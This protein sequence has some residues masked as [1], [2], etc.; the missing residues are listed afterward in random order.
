MVIIERA[1]ATPWRKLFQD[2]RATREIEL[3]ARYPAKDVSSWLGNS[4][5][6]AMKYQAMEESFQSAADPK[7]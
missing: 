4:T 3:M 2:L 6:V 1:G 7:G 5:P